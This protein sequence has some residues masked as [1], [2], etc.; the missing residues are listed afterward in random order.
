MKPKEGEHGRRN[1]VIDGEGHKQRQRRMC[2][3][4]KGLGRGIMLVRIGRSQGVIGAGPF[5]DKLDPLGI[6]YL[7]RNRSH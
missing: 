5:N 7:A 6:L 1:A 3:G 2:P 4:Q